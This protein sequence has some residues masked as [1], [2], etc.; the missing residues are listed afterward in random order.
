MFFVDD[1]GNKEFVYG[2]K[3]YSFYE[4]AVLKLAPTATKIEYKKSWEELFAKYSTLTAKE[5]AE[6]SGTPRK[7]S[8]QFLDELDVKGKLKKLTTK[9]GS[10]WKLM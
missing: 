9:N 3:P 5:F 7:E 8:E 4:V 2:S 6:L 1:K 10:I